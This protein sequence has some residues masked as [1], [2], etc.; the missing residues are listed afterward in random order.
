[1]SKTKTHST[2]AKECLTWFY[3]SGKKGV[4]NQ[5]SKKAFETFKKRFRPTKF[6]KT[7]VG[8]ILSKCGGSKSKKGS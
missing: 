2:K 1:L 8:K 4:V 6:C 5:D 3:F 7:Y